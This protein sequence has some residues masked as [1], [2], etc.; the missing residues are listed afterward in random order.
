M[1]ECGVFALTALWAV[2]GFLRGNLS[3]K[4][5]ALA[6]P[7]LALAAFAF[8]QTVEF[9]GAGR[10]ISAS[11]FAT[12]LF[13]F[14]LLSLVAAG[15]LLLT[16]VSSASRLRALICV[17]VGVGVASAFFGII[18][19]AAHHEGQGFVLPY[20]MPESGFAQFINR[21]HFAYLAEMSLGLAV[22]MAVCSRKGQ[23]RIFWAAAA[24]P[25]WISLV[26]SNSRGGI[27]SMA[28]Q[29]IFTLFL[30]TFRRHRAGRDRQG[31]HAGRRAWSPRILAYRLLLIGTILTAVGAGIVWVGGERLM[32]RL[33]TGGDVEASEEVE[34]VA[35]NRA[36]FWRATLRLVGDHPLVGTGFGAFR[37]AIT[38][39]HEGSGKLAPQEAHN[40]Y[41]EVLASG[42]LLGGLV[43]AWFTAALVFKSVR[44]LTRH[45]R[46]FWRYNG[47]GA[48]VGIVGVAIHSFVDFGLHVGVNAYVFTALVV[49]ATS[50]LQEGEHHPGVSIIGPESGRPVRR[51]S[52]AV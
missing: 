9:G 31:D 47:F 37:E 19:Q 32:G 12:Q 23:S 38:P 44:Q 36:D 15:Q 33:E 20:L 49:I 42:G 46:P 11:P 29:A 39:Y 50:R 21:N 51:E 26:L 5:P 52:V 13:A 6:L 3:I 16:Y 35:A 43:F 10:T 17:I 40:D 28:G 7:L 8:L 2:D 14:K 27:L 48:A 45:H 24:V 1:F 25:L 18:R 34:S 22:G 4:S 41:L 30:L